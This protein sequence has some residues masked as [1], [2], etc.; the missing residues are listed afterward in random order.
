[1]SSLTKEDGVILMLQKLPRLRVLD[2]C[3]LAVVGDSTLQALATSCPLLEDLDVTCTS[4]TEQG[5]VFFIHI[6][7]SI[8]TVRNRVSMFYCLVFLL[9]FALLPTSLEYTTKSRTRVLIVWWAWCL[10]MI[11]NNR[12]NAL[13]VFYP[14]IYLVR[15]A[16]RLTSFFTVLVALVWNV[17]I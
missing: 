16:T 12:E 7:L 17:K 2:L 13:S 5:C 11:S 8:I 9:F 3:G 14:V 1:M 6:P 15:Q 4:I 10:M